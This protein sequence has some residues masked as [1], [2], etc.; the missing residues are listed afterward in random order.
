M[1][2]TPLSASILQVIFLAFPLWLT[3]GVGQDASNEPGPGRELSWPVPDLK[4]IRPSLESFLSRADVPREA[5]Q[6]LG[7]LDL[8]QGDSHERVN[9]LLMEVAIFRDWVKTLVERP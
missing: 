4:E 3:V 9:D 1:K 7:Q 8:V 5:I 2:N 6:S